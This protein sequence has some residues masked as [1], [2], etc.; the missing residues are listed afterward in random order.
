MK[1][2]AAFPAL[3]LLIAILLAPGPAGAADEY[4]EQR[5]KTAFLVNF[6]AFVTWPSA[7]A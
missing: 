5:I 2:A 4:L 3:S 1:A 7:V 6:A